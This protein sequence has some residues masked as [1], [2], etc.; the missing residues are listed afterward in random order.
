MYRLVERGYVV[1]KRFTDVLPIDPD[2]PMLKA[3]WLRTVADRML[4]PQ[5]R[6]ANW[7]VVAHTTNM[8]LTEWLSL[9]EVQQEAVAL[10]VQAFLKEREKKNKEALDQFKNQ[11][12]AV[13]PQRSVFEGMVMPTPNLNR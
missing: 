1:P 7:V 9:D 10:E 2:L 4:R 12:E 13:K 5:M 3:N 6:L 8:S 11:I